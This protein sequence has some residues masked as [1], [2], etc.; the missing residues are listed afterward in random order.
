MWEKVSA[1]KHVI[2]KVEHEEPP[3]RPLLLSAETEPDESGL[4]AGAG[5]EASRLRSSGSS[6]KEETVSVKLAGTV[7]FRFKTAE[8]GKIVEWTA[9][10]H[11]DRRSWRFISY[12]VWF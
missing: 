5:A 1:R 9:Q 10:A 7:E 4:G 6:K 2:T 11:I 3:P 12:A 8:P